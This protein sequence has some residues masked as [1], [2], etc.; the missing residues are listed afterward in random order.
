VNSCE[1][2]KTDNLL[3]TLHVFLPF[4][5]VTADTRVLM[6]GLTVVEL[7]DAVNK[8]KSENAKQIKSQRKLI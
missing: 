6:S 2:V 8:R 5:N 4:P 7:L 3:K 1:T